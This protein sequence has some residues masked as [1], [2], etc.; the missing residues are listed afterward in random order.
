VKPVPCE[1]RSSASMLLQ[2]LEDLETWI[3]LAGTRLE[4]A[5][6]DLEAR[7][8]VR[9]A[10]LGFRLTVFGAA[11]NDHPTVAHAQARCPKRTVQ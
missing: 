8:H 11:G 1:L 9:P 6:N 10:A 5:E 2:D 4:Q 7:G 3:R